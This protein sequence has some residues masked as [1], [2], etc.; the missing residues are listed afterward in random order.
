MLSPRDRDVDA[1]RQHRARHDVAFC[2]RD[3][4]GRKFASRRRQ[5][6]ARDRLLLRSR[7]AERIDRSWSWSAAVRDRS[8]G[9]ALPRPQRKGSPRA[10]WPLYACS[11]FSGL[12]RSRPARAFA[13]E[14]F[15][16]TVRCAALRGLCCLLPRRASTSRCC[17]SPRWSPSSTFCCNGG[18]DAAVFAG[19]GALKH[20][21]RDANDADTRCCRITSVFRVP[22][23]CSGWRTPIPQHGRV[24]DIAALG[25]GVSA[26]FRRGARNAG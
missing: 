15:V 12:L 4:A 6:L 22:A 21:R 18:L 5:L 13:S 8:P 7:D 16:R 2:A 24:E 26:H 3:R 11:G 19:E 20:T 25:A 10:R 1:D 14:Q 9:C 17:C 23:R